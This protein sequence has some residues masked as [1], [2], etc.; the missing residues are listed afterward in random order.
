MRSSL[1]TTGSKA[2]IVTGS[3]EVTTSTFERLRAELVDDETQDVTGPGREMAELILAPE[4]AHVLPGFAENHLVIVHDD[5]M[6]RASR[7]QPGG[8][9]RGGPGVGERAVC[10]FRGN[11]ARP[12]FHDGLDSARR[13][14]DIAGS[15]EAGVCGVGESG[16]G[17]AQAPSDAT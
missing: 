7:I 3:Q 11:P 14:G 1:L 9:V 6:A 17:V 16:G 5:F 15:G 8:E 13:C 2:T 4:I 12:G 10:I